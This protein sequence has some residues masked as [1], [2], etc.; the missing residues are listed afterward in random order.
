VRA[1]ISRRLQEPKNL[2]FISGLAQ[3]PKKYNEKG[4][5]FFSVVLFSSAPPLPPAFISRFHIEIKDK[6]RIKEDAVLTEWRGPEPNKTTAKKRGRPLSIY[7]LCGIV[8]DHR[9]MIMLT[10]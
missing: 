3:G 4:P 9:R 6:E 2:S 10:I 8:Q 7:L 1:T 5:H